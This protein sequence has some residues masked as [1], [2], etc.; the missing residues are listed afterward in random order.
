VALE[1]Y[2]IEAREE[3]ERRAAEQKEQKLRWEIEA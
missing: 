1:N 3:E 2:E